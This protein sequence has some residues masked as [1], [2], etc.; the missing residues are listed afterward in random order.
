M[1]TNLK[2]KEQIILN[3]LQWMDNK[4]NKLDMDIETTEKLLN[5]LVDDLQVIPTRK[6]QY[7]LDGRETFYLR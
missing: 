4:N 6:T 1:L 2:M 7:Y 5:S 3:T